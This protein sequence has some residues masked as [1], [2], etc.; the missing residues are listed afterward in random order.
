MIGTTGSST[1]FGRVSGHC[2]TP[3]SL[4]P[5]PSALKWMAKQS[6]SIE[7]LC[8]SYA[9]IT[10][11]N[12]VHGMIFFPMFNTTTIRLSIAPLSIAHF[13]CGWD[14]NPWVSLMLHYLLQPH[15]HNIPMFSLRPIKPLESLSRFNT[16]TNRSMRFFRYPVLSTSNAMINIGYHTS[17]R[18]ETR[19]S[20]ICIKNTL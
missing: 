11:I 2:W 7:S 17:F 15:R 19:S 6:S 1:H 20:Y 18:W 9:C 16:S 12:H 5:L 8:T 14:S 13:R 3:S 4:N 10:L